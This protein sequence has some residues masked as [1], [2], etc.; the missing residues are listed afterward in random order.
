M[1][2]NICDAPTR[3]V[4]EKIEEIEAAKHVWA[5]YQNCDILIIATF[6]L[7]EYTTVRHPKLKCVKRSCNDMPDIIM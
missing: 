3:N 6:S 5:L 7:V 1:I 2:K 4:Q